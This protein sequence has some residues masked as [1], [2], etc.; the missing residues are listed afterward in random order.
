MKKFLILLALLPALASARMVDVARETTGH[1]DSF[2]DAL[3]GAL[4]QAVQ[5]VRGARM[6]TEPSLRTKVQQVVSDRTDVVTVEEELEQDVLARSDGWVKSYKVIQTTRPTDAQPR[7]SVTAKVVVPRFESDF[8]PGDERFTIAVMP[9]RVARAS[10]K[11]QDGTISASEASQRMQEAVQEKLAQSRRFSVVNRSFGE[12]FASENALLRSGLVSAEE[13]SR[14]GNVVGADLMLVGRIHHLGDSP[15]RKSFY[16]ADF[17]SNMLRVEVAWQ[18]L[19][20]ATQ[21]IIWSDVLRHDI[22]PHHDFEISET[23]DVASRVIGRDLLDVV[24]PLRVMDIVNEE[25]IFLTQGGDLI[26]KGALY[27]VHAPGREMKDPETGLQV[28][29]KGP[30]VAKIKVVQVEPQYS[31]GTLVEGELSDI[32]ARAVLRHQG[33]EKAPAPPPRQ[34]PGSS[35][36]PIQW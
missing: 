29:M 27:D 20:V 22:K 23:Y 33:M 15:K 24:Y 10:F 5:Q 18:V 12:E 26:R 28:S 7:W 1:G 14:A 16:G 32:E 9:F 19:E 17:N 21:K 25:R 36:K 2:Q 35:D 3:N 13:A 31:I 34:T 4:L 30:V 6:A 8:E 11:W